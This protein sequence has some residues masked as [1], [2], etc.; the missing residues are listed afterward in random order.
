MN[1][2]KYVILAYFHKNM[3]WDSSNESDAIFMLSF[4]LDIWFQGKS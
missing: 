1:V 4:V 3:L 2:F